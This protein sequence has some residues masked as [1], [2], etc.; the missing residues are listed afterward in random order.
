M[1]DVLE[2]ARALRNKPYR[3]RRYDR[4]IHQAICGRVQLT[5]AQID[6]MVAAQDQRLKAAYERLVA[7]N[8]RW[9]AQL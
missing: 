2:Q 7:A 6:R 1:S 5:Q 8:E 4:L 3:D 9:A